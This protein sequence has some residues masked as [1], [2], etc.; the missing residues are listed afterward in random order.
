MDSE[1]KIGD[2]K[3]L[4]VCCATKKIEANNTNIK[5][6][7]IIKYFLMFMYTKLLSFFLVG[8]LYILCITES[9]KFGEML[10]FGFGADNISFTFTKSL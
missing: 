4:F 9:V 2:F 7:A 5:L 3:L 8:S 10:I 6:E 1:S